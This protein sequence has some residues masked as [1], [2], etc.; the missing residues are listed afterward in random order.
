MGGVGENAHELEKNAKMLEKIITIIVSSSASAAATTLQDFSTAEL[1]ILHEHVDSLL[2]MS[3]FLLSGSSPAG[4]H[5]T[6]S[7][8]VLQE[9]NKCEIVMCT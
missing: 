3:F 4:V 1:K 7:L 6:S 2:S 9:D 5:S 8:I